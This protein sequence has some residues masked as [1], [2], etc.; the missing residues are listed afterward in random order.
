MAPS[1]SEFSLWSQATLQSIMVEESC[2]LH[3][4]QRERGAENKNTSF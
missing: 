4:G 2:P 3:G 1:L